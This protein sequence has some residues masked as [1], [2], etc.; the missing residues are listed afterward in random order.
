MRTQP[1]GFNADP[2]F[3]LANSPVSQ[4]D[5]LRLL[6][7]PSNAGAKQIK[8]ETPVPPNSSSQSL[9]AYESSYFG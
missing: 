2:T 3:S 7:A 8:F 9:R 1:P 4:L 6:T 5:R